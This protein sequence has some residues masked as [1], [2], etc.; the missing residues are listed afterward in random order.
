MRKKIRN[1]FP[2][3]D[4]RRELKDLEDRIARKVNSIHGVVTQ[5]EAERL[6]QL[7]RVVGE[8]WDAVN[9]KWKPLDPEE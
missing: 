6:E 9:M 5:A 3:L 7:R 1:P 2:V 4:Y 8:S